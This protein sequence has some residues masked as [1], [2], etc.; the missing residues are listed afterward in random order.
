M[1]TLRFI[2]YEKYN[3]NAVM[4][5]EK[6]KL[7]FDVPHKKYHRWVS[8]LADQNGPKLPQQQFSPVWYRIYV[9]QHRANE[10]NLSILM[11]DH[12]VLDWW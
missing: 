11:H 3:K 10:E 6:L 9:A 1:M 12:L 4:L 5:W 8:M 7:L 2:I